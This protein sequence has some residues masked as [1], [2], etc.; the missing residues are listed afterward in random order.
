MNGN[1]S[2]IN[3]FHNDSE[4][5][6]LEIGVTTILVYTIYE[7]LVNWKQGQNKPLPEHLFLNWK[8]FGLFDKGLAIILG[9]VY[10][11]KYKETIFSTTIELLMTVTGNSNN[12]WTISMPTV[13]KINNLSF[14]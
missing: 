1:N 4:C 7:P 5:R 11:G 9:L 6:Y 13:N 3:Y 10:R 2:N 8:E 14:D 12:I